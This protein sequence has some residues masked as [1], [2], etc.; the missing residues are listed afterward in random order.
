M[1]NLFA[2]GRI[3]VIRN[4]LMSAEAINRLAKAENMSVALSMLTDAGYNAEALKAGDFEKAI[5]LEQAKTIE[6]F[7]SVATNSSVRRVFLS[8]LNYHNA[9]ALLKIKFAGIKEGDLMLY[10]GS[11][12]SV[13]ELNRFIE[14]GDGNFDTNLHAAIREVIDTS[15]RESPRDI[16]L[17]ID[18]ALFE[19]IKNEI[20]GVKCTTLATYVKSEIDFINILSVLRTKPLNFS[21]DQL[22][23]SLISGGNIPLTTLIMAYANEQ[24]LEFLNSIRLYYPQ[25]IADVID[26]SA[27]GSVGDITLILE[28]EADNYLLKLFDEKKNNFTG[29]QPYIAYYLS[30]LNEIRVVKLI[31]IA[32]KYELPPEALAKRM[33]K[34]F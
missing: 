14:Q 22:A 1:G 18:G 19:V 21:V 7:E 15:K 24:P 6:V 31:L 3:V 23:S 25:V 16:D 17:T 34:I 33:R 26:G 27:Q 8:K 2:N 20:R 10:D 5:R 13:A 11:D 4:N 32:I 9:K 29:I 28:R 12:I 30:K